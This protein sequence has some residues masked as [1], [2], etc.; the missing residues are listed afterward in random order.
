MVCHHPVYK[1]NTIIHY[2]TIVLQKRSELTSHYNN[3]INQRTSIN[4]HEKTYFICY[5]SPS[6]RLIAIKC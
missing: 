4:T 6:I 5:I 1:K 2:N 3:N